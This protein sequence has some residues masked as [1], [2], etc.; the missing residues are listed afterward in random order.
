MKLSLQHL[1]KQY[2]HGP[3]ALDEVSL[4]ISPG[5]FGLLGPN[6]AGK[7]SLMRTIATLQE[8]DGGD[9]R[10]GDID[11][12]AQPERLRQVLGYL[13]QDFGVYPKVSA[14]DLLDHIAWIKGIGGNRERADLVAHTLHLVNLGE[15]G[16]R[17]L[18]TF[19]G[20][21]RQRFG[22]AQA[23]IGN[24]RLLIVDEPT[25]G[26]DPVE[27][28]RFYNILSELS[29]EIIV[30]LSTHIVEDVKT[31]CS[32]MAIMNKGRIVLEGQPAELVR[33]LDGQVWTMQSSKSTLEEDTRD[34]EVLSRIIRGEDYLL[35][36]RADHDHG[37]RLQSAEPNLE[38]LY[39]ATIH[40]PAEVAQ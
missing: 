38:D 26:L 24:P 35:R 21:M 32:R 8:P 1:R 40:R 28:N 3:L 19:S 10:L 17:L 33:T 2:R 29:S 14:R 18:G 36:V 25:A 27:R 4:D 34:M 7:S 15:H 6:G 16:G 37:G 20:G 31:L 39:F 13:P 5:M 22:I 12:L 30:L 9:I 11:V 23:I